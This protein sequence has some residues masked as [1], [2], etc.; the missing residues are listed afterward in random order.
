MKK[1]CPCCNTELFDR[2]NAY[3]C[4]RN[5]IGECIYDGYEAF[6]LEEE[7]HNLKERRNNHYLE[8]YISEID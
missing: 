1:Y 8:R 3:V 2:S 6:R 7:S 4:P 5:E